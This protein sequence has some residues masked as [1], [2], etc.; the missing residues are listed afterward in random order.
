MDNV[1]KYKV[2]TVYVPRPYSIKYAKKID[3]IKS[4]KIENKNIFEFLF[5]Y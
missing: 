1:D 4:V 3:N 2:Y 5:I